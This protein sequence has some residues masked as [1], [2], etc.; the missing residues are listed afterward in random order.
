M[1]IN[2][3]QLDIYRHL[4][5]KATN[6][7]NTGSDWCENRFIEIYKMVDEYIKKEKNDDNA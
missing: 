5:Y 3:Y 6:E 4:L 2:N 7:E 1:E